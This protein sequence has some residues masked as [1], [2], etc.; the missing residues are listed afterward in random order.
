MFKNRYLFLDLG[1][2]TR[3]L[4]TSRLKRRLFLLFTSTYKS[5][6]VERQKTDI[7]LDLRTL[8]TKNPLFSILIP[9]ESKITIPG[10]INVFYADSYAS[11]SH[12][13][14]YIFYDIVLQIP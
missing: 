12:K 9:R 2:S 14:A 6:N 5:S 3:P 10:I 4:N 1:G 11:F 8:K 13:K 7:F